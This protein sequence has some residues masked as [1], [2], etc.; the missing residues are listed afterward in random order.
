MHVVDGTMLDFLGVFFVAF[1]RVGLARSSVVSGFGWWHST[2]E[3]DAKVVKSV[4]VTRPPEKG[5]HRT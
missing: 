4:L 1:Q 3:S 5:V 2:R